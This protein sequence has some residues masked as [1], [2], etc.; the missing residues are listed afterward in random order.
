MTVKRGMLGG[1]LTVQGG[2]G[3]IS[4]GD[5]SIDAVDADEVCVS[6]ARVVNN[7]TVYN[8]VE[9]VGEAVVPAAAGNRRID[10]VEMPI[11]A[12]TAP[13]ILKGVEY[14]T[15]V[16]ETAFSSPGHDGYNWGSFTSQYIGFR[17]KNLTGDLI[18][19]K[20]LNATRM[21]TSASKART[22]YC[23]YATY[24]AGAPHTPQ[25]LTLLQTV[26]TAGYN[27]PDFNALDT[28]CPEIATDTVFFV[29]VA[30]AAD[31]EAYVR[32]NSKDGSTAA[33]YYIADYCSYVWNS[34][35]KAVVTQNNNLWD[36]DLYT[37]VGGGT[38]LAPTV[39]ADYIKLATIGSNDD[40]IT[41]NFTT[42]VLTDPDGD[43]TK[44]Q[45]VVETAAT[46]RLIR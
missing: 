35:T 36:M 21:P 28:L 24:S 38:V 45:L 42:L 13:K 40:P 7:G 17:L 16:E 11:T 4:G 5:V 37:L 25:T 19:L 31:S 1:M 20:R 26:A 23:Y 10:I 46:V 33:E 27:A 15:P 3:I 32:G 22:W 2:S 34:S 12:E 8:V 43:D 18:K 44:A 41:E 39:D 29:F 9:Q 14:G 30:C 6:A